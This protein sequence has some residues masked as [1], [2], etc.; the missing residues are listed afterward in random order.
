ME[1]VSKTYWNDKKS[2]NCGQL[3]GPLSPPLSTGVHI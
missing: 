3:Q 1:N 2:T